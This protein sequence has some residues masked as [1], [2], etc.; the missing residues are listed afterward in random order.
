[1]KKKANEIKKIAE[2]KRG[3]RANMGKDH[4]NANRCH[5]SNYHRDSGKEKGLNK[6]R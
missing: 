4:P 2:E 5:R 1:M 6:E 3:L